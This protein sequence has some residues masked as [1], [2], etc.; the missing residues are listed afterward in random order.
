MLHGR[1]TLAISA[2]FWSWKNHTITSW[3]RL[4]CCYMQGEVLKVVWLKK[5]LKVLT[6]MGSW[7]RRCSPTST[8]LTQVM[9][10]MFWLASDGLMAETVQ[11]LYWLDTGDEV[12]VLAGQWWAHGWDGAVLP[13]LT[14]HRWWG[15]C[16]GWPV[17]G[18]WLRRCSP[19]FLCR[20]PYFHFLL[21]NIIST[22]DLIVKPYTM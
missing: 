20:E 9:R 21:A 16:S 10:F 17:M 4:H 1:K 11:Y 5:K 12:Y 15:L 2:V 13:L 18:S 8:D 22:I 19:T 7:L 3:H 14:W 6:V